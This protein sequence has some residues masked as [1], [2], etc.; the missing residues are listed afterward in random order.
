MTLSEN[1]GNLIRGI[2]G[3]LAGWLGKALA[4]PQRTL[5]ALA[6]AVGV[7][8]GLGA[9]AFA[10]LIVAVERLCFEHL[11][12]VLLEHDL[13]FLL[14]PLLPAGGALF[15]G[16]ITHFIA[17][18]AEGHGV[19]EVMY[20]MAKEGGRIRPRVASAKAVASALTIG[21]GGSAGTEG[22]IIQIG[23]AI[24][25]G[26]GQWMRVGPGDLRVLIGCG[27]AAG[28]ASIFNAPI[29]GVL[30]AMEVLLRD[31]S[32]RN[33]VPII[34]SSVLS[35]TV[36]QAI[37]GRNE[38]IFQ[39]PA[40]IS[41]ANVASIYEYHWYEL[42]NYLV[43]GVLCGLV[44]VAFIWTLYRSEDLFRK[45]PAHPVARPVIGGL[46]IGLVGVGA[47]WLA[48]AHLPRIEGA[49]VIAASNRG[50]VTLSGSGGNQ[51][52]GSPAFEAPPVMGNGYPVISQTLE[53]DSYDPELN[54]HWAAW[55]LLLLLGGKL[56]ATVITLGS[57][58]SGG[59]F[60]P[61]LY[62]GATVGGAF[63]LAVQQ[64]GWFVDLSPGAYALV[65]MAAVVAGTIRAP[66][67]ATLILFELTRD[68]RVILPVMIAGVVALAVAQR[69]EPSS[70]Y[71]LKLLRRGIRFGLGAELR[72][73]KQIVVRDI[74]RAE[75]VIVRPDDPADELVRLGRER[76]VADFV[77]ADDEG[78]YVGM[79][80]GEDLRI[81]L[82]ESEAVPL[83]L[84]SE[85][86]R[87]DLPVVGLDETLDTV[88]E[89]FAGHH[90]A[91]LPVVGGDRSGRVEGL[92]SRAAV[93]NR[94]HQAL[95]AVEG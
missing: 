37:L 76:A 94:Y 68:Y 43:L 74:A 16:L 57:G 17:P 90:S 95:E 38:A 32:L 67:T 35:S 22:P 53:P 91:C 80:T 50:A 2:F 20:A 62:M 36:T 39:I 27:T 8:T 15:V 3:T 49:G 21:S 65:G 18:E 42:G 29:A 83:L 48:P 87:D 7:I 40:Q 46:L 88:L 73:L 34:V 55:F 93:M 75:A 86:L 23:A 41:G 25:S 26:F 79:V 47:A 52:E 4:S 78:R 6:V 70:I 61:S 12:G 69:V 82:L 51:G 10:A 89:K 24:G 13:H 33:F 19:P 44:A 9:T 31:T 85:L 11:G 28:I 60:A 59:V 72:I 77:V 71:T 14:L 84:V 58:G 64:T 45:L 63:G 92:L 56:L 54:V 81:A 1:A 66:L 5:T 30:F